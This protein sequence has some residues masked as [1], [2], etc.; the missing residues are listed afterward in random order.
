MKERPAMPKKSPPPSFV[1]L[2]TSPNELAGNKNFLNYMQKLL[3]MVPHLL[4]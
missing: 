3:Q 2:K 4:K 1:K